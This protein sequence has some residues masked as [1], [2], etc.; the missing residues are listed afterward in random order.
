MSTTSQRINVYKDVIV[1]GSVGIN[2]GEKI[3]NTYSCVSSYDIYDEKYHGASSL[4]AIIVPAQFTPGDITFLTSNSDAGAF[5]RLVL[6]DS[7]D[8]AIY[9]IPVPSLSE[10]FQIALIA[11]SFDFIRFLKIETSNAQT[12]KVEIGLVLSP[13]YQGVA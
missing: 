13:I 1:N 11:Y 6:S 8:I 10:Q 5:S 9:T 3:S 7:S 2:A 12:E 4:R